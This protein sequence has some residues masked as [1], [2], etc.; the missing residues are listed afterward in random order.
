MIGCRFSTLN[1]NEQRNISP[2]RMSTN[3]DY[4][5]KRKIRVRFKKIRETAKHIHSCGKNIQEQYARDLM[6]ANEI[7]EGCSD[8]N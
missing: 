6:E 8:W 7:K 1:R 5:K 4:Q 2:S 3:E